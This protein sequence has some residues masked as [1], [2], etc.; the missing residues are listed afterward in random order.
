M[1]PQ[2]IGI[3]IVQTKPIMYQPVIAMGGC[4]YRL[5]R[6]NVPINTSYEDYFAQV[7]GLRARAAVVSTL[8]EWQ[9]IRM[10]AEQVAR[11]CPH[12]DIARFCFRIIAQSLAAMQEI[13]QTVE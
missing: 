10:E 2:A 1:Y 5:M 11:K 3:F 12:F 13:K 6:I 8:L 7:E 9:N 4:R